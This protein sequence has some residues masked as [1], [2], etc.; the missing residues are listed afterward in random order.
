[1]PYVPLQRPEDTQCQ[2]AIVLEFCGE[3][4]VSRLGFVTFRV[5]AVR[6]PEEFFVR[7]PPFSEIVQNMRGNPDNRI[8][9]DEMWDAAEGAL[10]GA[11]KKAELDYDVNPGDGAFYG[12]KIDLHMTDSLG[13]SWQL[14][15]V[16][17]DYGMPERFG[18][19]Y[20]G[21]EAVG[22]VPSVV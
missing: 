6:N 9:T 4:F 14:G 20:T 3:S 17:L 22:V 11:L 16:Q 10:E 19:E 13:R 8:G 5:H 2:L 7:Y 21:D 15:T 1:V 18:L 12:P